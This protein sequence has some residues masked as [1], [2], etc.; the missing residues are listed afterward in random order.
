MQPPICGTGTRAPKRPARHTRPPPATKT[1]PHRPEPTAA[2]GAPHRQNRG[3]QNKHRANQ[4]CR[5]KQ[6]CCRTKGNN[7]GNGKGINA[8]V[9]VQPIPHRSTRNRRKP[10]IMRQ[11]IGA[12]SRKR[13][14]AERQLPIPDLNNGQPVIKRKNKVGQQ[15]AANRRPE[16]GGG[17]SLHGHADVGH[18][19]VSQ[20]MLHHHNGC[21]H[22]HQPEQM[23]QM[24]QPFFPPL[25]PFMKVRLLAGGLRHLRHLRP[26]PA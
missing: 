21:H 5:T 6:I 9:P 1:H 16:L 13:R 2:H 10:Q 3:F 7:L 20:F 18:F 17:N 14:S 24:L 11:N 12:E 25:A 4:D 26:D 19:K 22:Q 23:G 15:R 8:P